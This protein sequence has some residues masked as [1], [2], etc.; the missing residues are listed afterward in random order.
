MN[1]AV[2]VVTDNKEVDT[3]N[4]QDVI[5]REEEVINVETNNKER[6]IKIVGIQLVLLLIIIPQ[7][8]GILL[9]IQILQMKILGIQL[10]QLQILGIHLLVHQ[11]LQQ[12]VGMLYLKQSLQQ[13]VVGMLLKPPTI[14]ILKHQMLHKHPKLLHGLKKVKLLLL[15]LQQQQQQITMVGL[16]KQKPRLEV[17]GVI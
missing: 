6:I 3:L 17:H 8:L 1:N 11:H 5:K 16:H 4:N 13:I 7:T 12:I 2:D 10:L 14:G 15:L 9:P